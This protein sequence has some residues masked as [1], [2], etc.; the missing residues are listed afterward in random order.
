MSFFLYLIL[1][2]FL[3]FNSLYPHSHFAHFSNS[4]LLSVTDEAA[5]F[6]IGKSKLA[7]I[8]LNDLTVRN[9]E[10][11]KRVRPIPDFYVII[12]DTKNLNVIFKKVSLTC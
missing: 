10:S 4:R 2:F 9:V 11:L 6:F 3:Y 5:H 7:V 8:V 12:A 1:S